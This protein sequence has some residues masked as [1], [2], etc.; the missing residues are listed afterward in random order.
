MNKN[1]VTI[2]S[3]SK[4]GIA[5]IPPSSKEI[6]AT[7]FSLAEDKTQPCSPKGIENEPKNPTLYIEANKSQHVEKVVM[8]QEKFDKRFGY[9]RINIS[10][11]RKMYYHFNKVRRW[12]RYEWL[13]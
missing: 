13:D 11:G 8:D 5:S 10:L 6:S 3:S 4:T 12:G 2:P 7:P 1:V 9:R